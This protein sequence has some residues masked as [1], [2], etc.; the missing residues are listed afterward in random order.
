MEIDPMDDEIQ[1]LRSEIER[2]QKI[3]EGKQQVA[4]TPTSLIDNHEFIQD[5]CRYAEGI[6][7]KQDVKKKWR[8]TDD[9]I[10]TKLAN[11]EALI[12]QIEAEKIR[13]IRNGQAK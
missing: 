13:R 6:F 2:L 3:M 1:H 4:S 5:C 9:T 8:F 12:E 11:D 10:W 7:S